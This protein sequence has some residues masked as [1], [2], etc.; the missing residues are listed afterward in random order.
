MKTEKKDI[1]WRVILVYTFIL[2]AAVG[3]IVKVVIIQFH[4]GKMWKERIVEERIRYDS[5]EAIRGN[6]YDCNGNVLA[7][8]IPLFDLRMDVAS[9]EISDRL[10]EE[11]VD[12]LAYCLSNLFKDK[13]KREYA[14]ALRQERRAGNRYYL[15][16]RK[17]TYDE[18]SQ[19]RKFPLFRLGPYRGG[20]ILEERSQREMPFKLLAARTIGYQSGDGKVFVGLEGAYSK[21][22]QGVGG[23]RL[24]RKIANDVWVPVDEEYEI[25]P[26]NGHDLIAAI[27]IN[28]QD[29]AEHALLEQ[30]L[31][32][33]ADH[34]CAVL[35]EVSTGYIRAIANLGKTGD[36]TYDEIYNYAVG[37][38]SEPGST[39]KLASLMV[40]LE[41]K[42][43]RLTDNVVTG[44][45]TVTFHGRTMRDVHPIGNGTITVRE[46]FEQSSNVG[47]S[48]IIVN[49]YQQDPRQFTEHLCQIGLQRK[50]NL[51]IS[52]EGLPLIKSPEDSTWSKVTLPWMSTGYEVLITPLQLLTLY[53]AVANNGVMVKPQFV[54]EIRHSGKT[55]KAITPEV[56]NPA[57]CSPETIHQ[58]QL[59]LEGVVENGTAQNVRNPVYKIAGKTGTAQIATAGEGYDKQNYKASFVGYFPADNPQYSCIV[60]IFKPNKGIYYGSQIAAPVFKDVADKVYAINP[61]I[62]YSVLPPADTTFLPDTAR[63]E[64]SDLVEICQS[65][66]LIPP[67]P[68]KQSPWIM[69]SRKDQHLVYEEVILSDTAVPDMTGMGARDAIFLLESIGLKPQIMGKGKVSSQSP[70]PGSPLIKGEWVIL[71]LRSS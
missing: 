4:E 29:V 46:A 54:E 59:L 42:K 66:R 28:I 20:M 43:V 22:L 63:S 36:S 62:H 61:D 18:V 67:P 3:I 33:N 41:D 57:V 39:F 26:Q 2:L 1:F 31:A 68:V 55:V 5:V 13:S 30:L 70:A 15:I 11:Q 71:T 27:D 24:V 23:K 8:S 25:Q 64:F 60:V 14:Q 56:L 44:D 69:L 47:I 10:F 53:N 19:L 9:T 40:A 38:S 32:H 21:E 49:A 17:V 16:Q 35:M 65:L 48:K 52:G 7:S 34:G 37:E 58:L 12:S 45:G 50:L 6:I 51:D